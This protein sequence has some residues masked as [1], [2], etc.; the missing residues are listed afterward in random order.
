MI[1][2]TLK[3]IF[4]VLFSK[5]FKKVA[6]SIQ[7]IKQTFYYDTREIG[8][9]EHYAGQTEYAEV[10]QRAR[11]FIWLWF[12]ISDYPKYLIRAQICKYYGHKWVDESY[13]GP[14]SGCISF[15]CERCY[16]GTH[17]QLY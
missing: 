6:S 12:L 3:E 8:M 14:E 1:V 13:G 5:L 16:I 15:W 11:L 7:Q 17:T 2:P 9:D 4:V 10:L